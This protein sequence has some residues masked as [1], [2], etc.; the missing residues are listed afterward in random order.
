MLTK[1]RAFLFLKNLDLLEGLREQLLQLKYLLCFCEKVIW[2]VS[3]WLHF[4]FV[5]SNLARRSTVRCQWRCETWRGSV[6]LKVYRIGS[7]WLCY[8]KTV[9]IKEGHFFALELRKLGIYF[10]ARTR[11]LSCAWNPNFTAVILCPKW[12]TIPCSAVL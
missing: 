4:P 9:T 2:R 3:L 12:N 11:V 1:H 8:F 10:E 5:V 7:F 6:V